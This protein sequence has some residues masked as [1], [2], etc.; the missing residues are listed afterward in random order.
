MSVIKPEGNFF[1]K[2]QSRSRVVN[3]I[4]DGFFGN[5]DMLLDGIEFST[6]YEAGCGEGYISH[7]IYNYSLEKQ[8]RIKIVA[9]DLSEKVVDK[10]KCD[11]PH[12]FFRVN[13]I[14]DLR[15]ESELYDLVVASEVLEH[16]EEPKAALDEIFRV[17]KRY[18]L[19]SVPN[20]PI[21]RISN[22]LR[23][24]Y[25]GSMGNTP[26][27]IKHWSKMQIVRLVGEYGKILEVR[28]PFPWTMILCE[29][30]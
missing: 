19:I 24:K 9:S 5:F 13:S 25:V 22:L 30:K 3:L 2:Y 23:G 21:W 15:E 18:T 17:S 12:I 1:D 20:E 4:M 16:L 29:K 28:C 7:H 8:K 14:Y 6:V 27:H 26:G 11:F 10:A